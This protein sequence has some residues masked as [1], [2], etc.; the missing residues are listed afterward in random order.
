M[1]RAQLETYDD[2]EVTTFLMDKNV[3]VEVRV[4][5]LMFSCVYHA[6]SKL[7]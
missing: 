6:N 7:L 1:F 2:L 3:D 5:S 4:P